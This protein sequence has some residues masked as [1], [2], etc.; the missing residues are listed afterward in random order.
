[1]SEDQSMKIVEQQQQYLYKEMNWS[2]S[3]HWCQRPF[4]TVSSSSKF[5]TL[6][7][8]LDMDLCQTLQDFSFLKH[9]L[10]ADQQ[11][12]YVTNIK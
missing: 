7:A 6:N 11:I 4:G 9:Q 3:Q 10:T 1:M 2:T 8:Y 5:T 12:N